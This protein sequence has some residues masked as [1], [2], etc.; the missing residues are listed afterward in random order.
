MRG[1]NGEHGDPL[2]G[3]YKGYWC[4]PSTRNAGSGSGTLYWNTA[5]TYDKSRQFGY[6]ACTAKKNDVGPMVWGC[7]WS[8]DEMQKMCDA[9]AEVR[10]NCEKSCDLCKPEKVV[11]SD[12]TFS[13]GTD[14][15]DFPVFYKDYDAGS[16]EF[17]LDVK[18][19]SATVKYAL[20]RVGEHPVVTKAAKSGCVDLA[21]PTACKAAC[22]ADDSCNEVWAYDNGRCCMKESSETGAGATW[23]KIPAGSY[24]RKEKNT[25]V[26]LNAAAS[27]MM[28]FAFVQFKDTKAVTNGALEVLEAG[29]EARA[30]EGFERVGTDTVTFTHGN[31][32]LQWPIFKKEYKK[33]DEVSFAFKESSMAATF[34]KF[35]DVQRVGG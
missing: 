6:S 2:R 27:S 28:G 19:T 9:S 12:M 34:V 31:D 24:F 18:G 1:G 17:T 23:R 29:A 21:D 16:H 30:P 4:E 26:E 20:V 10:A 8:G 7:P 11:S 13:H 5:G 22:T 33:G 15:V 25:P 32:E 14:S 35:K 3:V